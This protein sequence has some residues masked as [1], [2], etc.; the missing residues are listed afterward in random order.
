MKE[1][2]IYAIAAIASLAILA[3]SIHMFVGG[4]V[5]PELE[6][7]LMIGGTL[8]GAAV[9]AFMARDVMRRRRENLTNDR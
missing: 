7:W 4:L 2:I 1:I 3:Y 6:R 5:S 9:I 8:I